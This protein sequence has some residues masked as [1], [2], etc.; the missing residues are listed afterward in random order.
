VD[1]AHIR[2]YYHQLTKALANAPEPALDGAAKFMVELVAKQGLQDLVVDVG[3]SASAE[4][5]KILKCALDL[6]DTD[7]FYW[8]LYDSVVPLQIA[9]MVQRALASMEP[10]VSGADRMANLLE[11]KWVRVSTS[12]GRD[13]EEMYEPLL[14]ELYRR[15]QKAIARG[16]DEA[17]RLELFALTGHSFELPKKLAQLLTMPGFD[18][19]ELWHATVFNR[20]PLLSP[21]PAE[22]GLAGSS[23]APPTSPEPLRHRFRCRCPRLMRLSYPV[24][25]RL[26]RVRETGA[27]PLRPGVA[28]GVR[29]N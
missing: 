7:G 10:P 3:R 19:E 14:A 11:E 29:T 17:G 22:R 27:H 4:A 12:L 8:L 20:A 1:D 16:G 24:W 13:V 9:W 18:P 28:N 5:D 15:V 21:R 23:S 25:F 26:G 6:D 2:W